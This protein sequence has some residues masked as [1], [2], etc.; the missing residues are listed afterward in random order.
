MKRY[1]DRRARE[2][3]DWW[4]GK[5][6]FEAC[7]REGWEDERNRLADVLE[8][9]NPASTLDVACGTGF[10]THNLR[11]DLTCVDQSEQMLAIAEAR[12]PYASFVHADVPPLPFADG[13]FDRVFTSHFYG[14]LEE[15][16]RSLFLTES[17]RVAQ[18]LV[19]VDAALRVEVQPEERQLRTLM[20][21]SRWKVYKRYFTGASLAGELGGGKILHE[22]RWFVAVRTS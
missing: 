18:E 13:S 1:Y 2:Y 4:L 17:R 19:V 15:P 12:I 9:L 16:E 5:G 6:L 22:G 3:D 11:G 20:D 10:L 21:G 7:E 8:Q 14:H